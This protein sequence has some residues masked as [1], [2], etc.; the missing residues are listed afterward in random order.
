M[1]QHNI[2]DTDAIAEYLS[3]GYTLE[4]KTF[5]K[6]LKYKPQ[7]M[8]YPR[9]I[10]TNTSI[11]VIHSTLE[12]YFNSYS[13]KKV[14]VLLSGGK[15]SRLIL[16]MCNRLDLDTT[17]ITIGYNEDMNE[18]I[19]AKKVSSKL[20]VPHRFLRIN[21]VYSYENMKKIVS[22][23][24]YPPGFIR[25][26]FYHFRKVFSEYAAV[27][28]GD[29]MTYPLRED[30][31]YQPK[32]H[33]DRLLRAIHFNPIVKTKYKDK[34]K[35]KLISE[36]KGKS[37][38]EICLQKIL[39]SR[40]RSLDSTKKLFNLEFPALNDEV[41]NVMWSMPEKENVKKIL[42]KYN[43]K[44]YNMR[45]TR[46]PFPLSTPWLIHYAYDR[47]NRISQGCWSGYEDIRDSVFRELK[48]KTDIK[49]IDL[50]IIDKNAAVNLK[51]AERLIKLKLYMER[52][53]G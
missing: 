19:V 28:R 22:L 25:P 42:K 1:K 52:K 48:E 34:V 17:S 40:F 3:I 36:Y 10:K 51:A 23:S 47:F 13:G 14:A 32:D 53:D 9:F 24:K 31:F 39:N 18:N 5:E 29:H 26:Y 12:K 41:L 4:G 8:E 44:T 45:C 50:D 11:P 6:G 7:N 21:D 30:K 49:N 33:L 46:S 37:L 15:D 16:E 2:L 20:G 35:Q 27:F 38:N 43:Y